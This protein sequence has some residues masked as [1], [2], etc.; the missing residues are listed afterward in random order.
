MKMEVYLFDHFESIQ[1]LYM[2]VHLFVKQKIQR[3]V[4]EQHQ[5][6]LNHVSV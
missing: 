1:N 3:V 5:S 2:L 4:Y 6:N